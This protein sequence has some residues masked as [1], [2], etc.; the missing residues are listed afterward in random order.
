MATTTATNMATAATG[1]T[2]AATGMST[3]ATG[4]STA[5][6]GMSTATATAM[7]GADSSRRPHQRGQPQN[8]DARSKKDTP[9]DRFSLHH[10]N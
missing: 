5:T 10:R 8:Q 7:R 3:A 2:T 4:M 9:H 1:M 6:T